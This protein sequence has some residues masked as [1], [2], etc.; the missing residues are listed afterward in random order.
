MRDAKILMIGWE[1]PP[2]ITGGLGVACKEIARNIASMG[3]K[4]DF[5]V[6]RLH[7]NEE[8]IDGIRLL[9]IRKG[10]DLL[11]IDE[12]E[13]LIRE[14]EMI[15]ESL[16]E[17]LMFSPY[18]SP[19]KTEGWS[20]RITRSSIYTEE[21]VEVPE[22]SEQIP[23]IS[24]GYG[25]DLF[26]DIR[27]FAKIISLLGE[28]LRPDLIHAHDWMTFIAANE[29]KQRRNI[30]IILHVHATEFDRC[31]ENGNDEIKRIEREG[32]ESADRIVSVS[33]YTKS[34]IRER[35]GIDENKIYVAHN[36][37][38]S[39]EKEEENSQE[40]NITD[41]IVLFLGRITHQ[42]GPDYFIRAAAKIVREIPDVKFVM[43]GSGDLQNR[44][45][46]LA[47]DLGLGGYFHY[48][49][50]LNEEKTHR[51]YNMCSVFIMPSVSEPFG[52][53]A[54]EAMSHKRPVVLSKQ[55]G[56][57]E[58]VNQCLKFDFWDTDS[59]AEKTISILKYGPLREEIGNQA[60][61]ESERINWTATAKKIANVYRSF[62]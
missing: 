56:V 2:N 34:I 41:P 18:F 17:R 11:G 9:D 19:G 43:A 54:L 31:G 3:Y 32:F 50:Y 47:A 59:L 51:L 46:E 26:Y 62:L 29:L 58:I 48:T 15:L 22:L 13:E 21:G 8:E 42:K 1:Y 4:V 30:P 40:N 25:P 61:A 5:I 27:K 45:I 52:L 7:G 37:I 14:N 53:T 16:P 57:S 55:S 28:K 6:P 44:M 38:S 33:E 10:W 24:G 49:G 35:Y 60:R 36:G 39:L 23:E 12:K 20:K